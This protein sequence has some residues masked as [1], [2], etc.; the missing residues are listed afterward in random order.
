MPYLKRLAPVPEPIDCKILTAALELF[1]KKGYHTVSVHQIQRLA[2]VSIG[3]IYNHFGGKEG[4]AKA[5]YVH[6][7]IEF[8][9]LVDDGIASSDSPSEQ[10]RKIIELMFEY[11]ESHADIMAYL[12]NIRHA[13]FLSDQL[14]LC[15]SAGFVK[16]DQLIKA[17]IA[18]GEFRAMD[19]LVASSC[20]FGGAIRMIQLRLDG[21]IQQPLPELLEQT[22]AGILAGVC[23]VEGASKAMPDDAMT[24]KDTPVIASIA[25]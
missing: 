17:G 13:E 6:L 14:L 7:C 22:V 8:D 20:L 15:E 24:A 16:I 25:V 10:Y 19:P 1:V 9:E 18:A 3:S 23:A 21:L 5:L 11:T 12:F 2:N 4:V